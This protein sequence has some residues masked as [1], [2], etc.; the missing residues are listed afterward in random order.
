V[1]VVFFENLL[2]FSVFAGYC[3]SALQPVRNSF[4]L[5]QWHG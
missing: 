5:N 4:A 3:Q 2:N 1:H